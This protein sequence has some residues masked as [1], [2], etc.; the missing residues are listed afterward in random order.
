[1]RRFALAASGLVGHGAA[2]TIE[3]LIARYGLF[4]LFVGAGI[5]GETVVVTG[6]LF[7]RQGLVPLAGAM[8]VTA[9]GS[10]LAAQLLFTLGRRYRDHPRVRRI[11]D[12][13]GFARALALLER[14]PTGFI[15]G[16]RFIYGLRTVSPIAI[17][18]SRIDRRR[19]VL[20][21]AL[22]AAIWGAAFTTAGYLFGE[23]IE[24]A[25]GRVRSVAHLWPVV[26]AVAVVALIV[27][28]LVRRRR[29]QDLDPSPPRA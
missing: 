28:I 5:E 9:A 6:G 18:A 19:F 11:A 25:F 14:H 21:N 1:M 27:A 4:T 15:F 8:A 10:F 3:T 24:H 2:V 26:A 7:A 16:F 23:A 29:G 13:P 17:G 22:A 20:L 12:R